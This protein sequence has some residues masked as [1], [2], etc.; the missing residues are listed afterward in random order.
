[1]LTPPDPVNGQCNAA[2]FWNLFYARRKISVWKTEYNS[3]R[4]HSSLGYMTPNEFP[5]Q[6]RLFRLLMIRVGQLNSHVKATLTGSA[7]LPALEMAAPLP[8][9]PVHVQALVAQLVGRAFVIAASDD[10]SRRLNLAPKS[11]LFSA[12]S[13]PS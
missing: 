10:L 7:S 8:A 12:Q 4:I 11:G 1:L 5:R 6:W 3:R 2:V 13:C 9:E